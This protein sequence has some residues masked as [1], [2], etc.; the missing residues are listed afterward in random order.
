MDYLDIKNLPKDLLN[1]LSYSLM[2]PFWY[3]AIYIFHPK[4]YA[5][6]DTILIAALTICLTIISTTITTSIVILVSYEKKLGL[7]NII[8][9]YPSIFFEIIFF[10][11]ILILSYIS[12]IEFNCAFKFYGFVS[13]IIVPKILLMYYFDNQNRKKEKTKIEAGVN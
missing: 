2:L 9:L 3:I 7:L 4:L 11:L 10:S 13:A 12:K 6:D 8:N 1:L 5:I